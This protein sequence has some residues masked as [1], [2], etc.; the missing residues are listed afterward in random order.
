MNEAEWRACTEPQK[1]L[2][3]LRTSDN[4]SERKARLFDVG[5]CRRIWSLL[6]QI[7]SRAVE[8]AE[9][10]ADG[11]ASAVE[12]SGAE[13]LAWW[14]AD[15]LN[16]EEEHIRAAAWAAH[17]AVEGEDSVQTAVLAARAAG[18]EDEPV[19]QCVLLRDIFG[20]P[21][22]LPPSLA[23]SVLRWHDGIVVRVASA[24]YESREL[25]SGHLDLARLAVLADSLEDAGCTD[26]HLLTHLR[27]EGPHVRGCWVIDLLLGKS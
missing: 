14:G 7:G 15:G 3:V 22:R 25:P 23:P 6:D 4:L 17:E 2:E 27:G 19:G 26:A 9:R 12:R 21:F 20:N 16:Y 1:M 13:N 8:V 18:C 24:I 10:Y 5:C 11:L